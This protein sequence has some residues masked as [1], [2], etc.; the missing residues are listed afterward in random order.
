MV[1]LSSAYSFH[2]LYELKLK[3]YLCGVFFEIYNIETATRYH[4]PQYLPP[5]QACIIISLGLPF[6]IYNNT[7]DSYQVS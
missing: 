2:D 7:W 6:I 1:G 3:N 4:K 5:E